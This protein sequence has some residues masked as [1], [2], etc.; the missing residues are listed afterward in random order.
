[1][2]ML[3]EAVDN[4]LLRKNTL[5]FRY[6]LLRQNVQ[7]VFLSCHMIVDKTAEFVYLPYIP[8]KLLTLLQF[9]TR[10][11]CIGILQVRILILYYKCY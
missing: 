3:Q 7:H 9:T 6:S 1:M 8:T 10:L 5:V 4:S 2:D 11:N